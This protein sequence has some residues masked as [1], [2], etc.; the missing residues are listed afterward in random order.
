MLLVY[1]QSASQGKKQNVWKTP[2]KNARV[3]FVQ[4]KDVCTHCLCRCKSTVHAS[5]HADS[6]RLTSHVYTCTLLM[7]S[8]FHAHTGFVASDFQVV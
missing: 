3:K 7:S 2:S 8:I 1:G 6:S 4:S 5:Q